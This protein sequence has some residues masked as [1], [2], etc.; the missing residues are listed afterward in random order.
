MNF[1]FCKNKYF[2][3]SE[4]NMN[5]EVSV[6]SNFIECGHVIKVCESKKTAQE[7]LNKLYAA[8]YDYKEF[9]TRK[10]IDDMIIKLSNKVMVA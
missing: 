6:R 3:I 2:H 9:L 4:G 10:N 8:L 1:E 7:I 5:I